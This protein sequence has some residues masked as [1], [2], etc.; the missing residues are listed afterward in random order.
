MI[1]LNMGMFFVQ[2]LFLYSS[3]SEME[4]HFSVL[5]ITNVDFDYCF[6][7]MST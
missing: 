4:T 1:S 5:L 3:P 2:L 7:I 6:N